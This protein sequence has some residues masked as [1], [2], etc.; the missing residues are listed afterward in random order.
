MIRNLEVEENVKNQTR[1]NN[2]QYRTDTDDEGDKGKRLWRWTHL[3]SIILIIINYIGQIPIYLYLI[4]LATSYRR[5]VG[6]AIDNQ[7][8]INYYNN[9]SINLKTIAI[10]Q[11]NFVRLKEKS[12][13]EH[14][15]P[16]FKVLH[17]FSL[18]YTFA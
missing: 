18:K 5:R 17:I 8:I 6:R 4:N 2:L 7:S 16:L 13:Y 1:G 15:L 3:D 9:N 14:S 11:K 10:L 12:K